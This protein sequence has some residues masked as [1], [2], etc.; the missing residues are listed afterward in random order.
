MR[1]L[2][3]NGTKSWAGI[4]TWMLELAVYLRAQ[5]DHVEFLCRKNDLLVQRCQENNLDVT[6]INFYSDYHPLSVAK[7]YSLLKKKKIDL[8]IT[9]ISKEV[10]TAGVAAKLKGIPHI[11]R[12]GNFGDLKHSLHNK[13]DYGLL[14]DK[15]IVP[16]QALKT[17]FA[18][19]P[20]LKDK[21][22]VHPNGMRF[23]EGEAKIVN[24]QE[25]GET[26]EFAVLANLT[27]RKQ[28]DKIIEVFSSLK[29]G[30]WRLHIGGEGPELERLKQMAAAT[31]CRNKI[32]F[33]GFVNP[34]DFFKDKHV[35]I[36]YSLQE[37]F[38]WVIIE[39]M[40]CHCAVIGPDIPGVTE[41]IRKD[42][43]GLLVDPKDKN[44]LS[45]AVTR[46]IEDSDELHKLRNAGYQ[47]AFLAFNQKTVFSQ[48]R[49][50]LID[51]I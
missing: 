37:S 47:R 28:V 3:A 4:K 21:L 27:P 40:S 1:V 46:L 38:G 11:N 6:E 48:L 43:D 7:I 8:L 32:D 49:K 14:V 23:E 44:A 18:Q 34:K 25:K 15:I 13:V 2:M 10:R 33:N 30:R 24:D 22:M 42:I 35:G 36:L 41:V 50:A 51:C 26:I 29:N 16:S 9:N 20:Y 39:A 17:D 19:H 45:D 5:G 31:R 12:L